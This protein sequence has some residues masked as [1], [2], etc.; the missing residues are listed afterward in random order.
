[1]TEQE[2]LACDNP[3]RMLASLTQGL[4][5]LPAD[6]CRTPSARQLRLFT[7][8]CARHMWDK[9]GEA[10]SRAAVEMAERI[11]DGELPCADLK[12][13]LPRP[14]QYYSLGWVAALC[15]WDDIAV[16]ASNLVDRLPRH[17]L[18]M[19][20]TQCALL[21]DIIGNPFRPVV[22]RSSLQDCSAWPCPTCVPWAT[23]T[24]FAIAQRIYTERDWEAM[25]ILRDSL[26]DS[27]CD[28]EEILAHLLEPLHV[29]GCWATDLI[30]GK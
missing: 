4:E 5:G 26:M 10:H 30:L 8:A 2:F 13:R 3:A 19:P 17:D 14:L 29:R 15:C 22:L 7:C 23:P 1:M 24:A 18:V 11:A 25:P 16:G 12:A 21:R 20:A 6:Y 27:G 28:S 9:L